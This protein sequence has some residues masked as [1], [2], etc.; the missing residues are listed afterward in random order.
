MSREGL[1]AVLKAKGV[2]ADLLALIR[3]YYRDKSAA[4]AVEGGLSEGFGLESGIGQGCCL[5]P[6]LFNLFFGTVIETWQHVSGGRLCWET[7]LDGVLRRQCCLEKCAR[8][9]K[10]SFQE[11]GYADDLAAVT[12][13]LDRLRKLYLDLSSHL[14]H[15]GLE[16][17]CDKKKGYGCLSK[18]YGPA[19]GNA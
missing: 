10:L 16:L 9:D 7:R 14:S 17:S 18:L 11:L 12:D 8:S 2:P 4:M 13:T 3:E 5:A 15:W 1:W 6:L 19:G